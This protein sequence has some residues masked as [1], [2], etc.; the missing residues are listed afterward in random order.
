MANFGP[1][2]LTAEIGSGIWGTPIRIST[3]FASWQRYCT[4]LY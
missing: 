1:L 3:G 4:A 2:G